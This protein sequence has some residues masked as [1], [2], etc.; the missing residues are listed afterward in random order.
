MEYLGKTAYRW[1]SRMSPL[2][3]FMFAL[4]VAGHAL[5]N[6]AMYAENAG[7]GKL[8]VRLRGIAEAMW[9]DLG[10]KT[11][12]FADEAEK[13]LAA[14]RKEVTEDGS[15][16]AEAALNALDL[17][18]NALEASTL[19]SENPARVASDLSFDIIASA[20]A[21]RKGEPLSDEEL[22]ES[23]LINAERDFEIDLISFIREKSGGPKHERLREMSD[24]D[25]VSNIGISLK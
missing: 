8:A 18:E 14:L 10:G 3:Q 6:F 16:G 19:R 24:A 23:A 7:R 25:G 20:E 12:D 9:D 2:Q 15:F 11:D 17:M 1:L 13:S 4:A 22:D 21:T 5:P